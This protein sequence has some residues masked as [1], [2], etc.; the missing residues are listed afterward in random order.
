MRHRRTSS[1]IA[2]FTSSA[3]YLNATFNA[4]GSSDP[5][6][7][8][9]SYAW[10]FGDSTTGTGVTPSHTYAAGGTYQVIL[11][12]TDNQGATNSVTQALTVVANQVP[13][14]AFTPTCTNLGCSFDG[15]ASADADGSIASYA[16]DFGGGA[17]ST[18][19]TTSRTYTAARHVRRDADRD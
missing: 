6:G 11:T 14:A 1:P 16:W 9:A 3:S 15:S 18:G 7:S 8:I 10:D 2:A 4:D 5:D 13:V 17:T 19:A 12:V